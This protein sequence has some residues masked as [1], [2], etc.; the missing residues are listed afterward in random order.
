MY[1]AV[2][3]LD[4]RGAPNIWQISN[5]TPTGVEQIMPTKLIFTPHPPSRFS[6]L[7]T[8]LYV[9]LLAPVKKVNCTLRDVL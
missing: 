1:R 6:D 9:S 8:A 7:P 2:K 4:V 5:P 3:N